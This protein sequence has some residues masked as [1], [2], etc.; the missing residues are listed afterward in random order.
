MQKVE[1]SDVEDNSDSENKQLFDN[2]VQSEMIENH[3]LDPRAGRIDVELPQIPFD[4][5]NIVKLLKQYRFH[6]QSSSKSRRQIS[7]LLAEY[8]LCVV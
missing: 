8:V 6:W 2:E 3:P 5:A 7:R 4:A 1:I